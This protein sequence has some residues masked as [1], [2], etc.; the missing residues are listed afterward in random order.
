MIYT[1][2]FVPVESFTSPQ[3]GIFASLFLKNP[4][5]KPSN[6]A[7]IDSST[8][9]EVTY[10][11]L[12]ASSLRLA[13]GLSQ[14]LP[15]GATVALLSPNSLLFP[16]VLF[17][18]IAAG[19]VVSGASP[20]ATAPELKYQLKDSEAT[21]M[22]AA[23]ELRVVAREAAHAAG[24]APGQV[25]L[26]PREDGTYGEK[27]GEQDFS[28]LIGSDGFAP[29][30][31]DDPANT[32]LRQCPLLSK[33]EVTIC[34]MP[35]Y[36]AGGLIGSCHVSFL[37]GGTVV[38]MPKFDL[39]EF[40]AAVQKHKVKGGCIVPPVALALTKS[41]ILDKYDLSSLDWIMV[42]AAP[43]SAGL[44]RMTE[45]TAVCLLPDLDD[46]LGGACGKPVAN[47]EIRLVDDDGNDVHP[48]DTG[49]MW[50]RGRSIMLGYHK[51][52]KAT[53]E[54]ITDDGWLKTGDIV[55]RT[56]TGNFTIVD[57]KK[58][59]IKTNAFQVAP[60]ELE[61][62]LISCPHVIDCAVIGVWSTDKHTEFPRGYVVLEPSSAHLPNITTTIAEYVAARVSH[63]RRLGAGVVVLDAIPKSPTGKILRK[64]LRAKV[65]KEEAEKARL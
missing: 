54:S 3:N 8:G 61:G 55:Q 43:L 6:I 19:M 30:K 60:A 12:I 2:P 23:W 26:L 41:P 15:R 1:S 13:S 57:R 17:G 49:E 35:L 65:A 42:G 50:V 63:Y 45:T 33:T 18:C 64:E 9:V 28:L 22:I 40:C 51:N 21:I 37:G 32:V 44:Q 62:V 4:L 52:A 59:L 34:S 16:T 48:G 36:H 25:F 58:E 56:E 5:V 53:R 20:S 39:E 38:I 24:W 47:V 10:G 27:E 11:A 7:L 31:I 46:F 14:A 29:V